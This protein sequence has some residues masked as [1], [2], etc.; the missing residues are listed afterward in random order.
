V[1][2][3]HHCWLAFHFDLRFAFFRLGM[4]SL[5]LRPKRGRR[6]HLIDAALD[7]HQN[8]CCSHAQFARVSI[9]RRSATARHCARPTFKVC[10]NFVLQSGGHEAG[11]QLHVRTVLV[12]V[13][14]VIFAWQC[15]GRAMT[16]VTG[17]VMTCMMACSRPMKRM[18][19]SS[20]V[21]RSLS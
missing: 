16:C 8:A 15:D 2:V 3:C 10:R 13:M 11:A 7:F 18:R 1:L 6:D 5:G 17:R 21:S 20:G 9:S 4:S 14:L 12:A 19:S